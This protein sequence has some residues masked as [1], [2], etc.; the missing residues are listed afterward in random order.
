[1][2][3]TKLTVRF[4]ERLRPAEGKSYAVRDTITRGLMVEVHQ[5]SKVYKVQR[6]VYSSERDTNGRRRKVGTRKVKLGDVQDYD[7]V[8]EARA[9]AREIIRE[10]QRGVDPRQERREALTLRGAWEIYHDYLVA[11]DR[12]PATIDGYR[13]K[14]DLYFPD[15]WDRTM[16]D[17]G[18]DRAAVYER[19]RWLARERGE[20]AANQ[21]MRALRAVYRRARRHHPEL[22]EHPV[23]VVDFRQERRR[24]GAAMS[25]EDLPGWWGEVRALSNPIRRDAQLLGLLSGLRA[26][27]EGHRGGGF[28]LV[29][30][31]WEHVD[32]KARA[33]RLPTT[34]TGRPL[35]IPLS[36]PMVE[37]L[38]RRQAENEALHAGSPWVFPADSKT[39][40][41][42]SLHEQSSGKR[43]VSVTG[44][45]LRH[46]YVTLGQAAGVPREIVSRLVGHSA[47]GNIT[48]SYTHVDAQIEYL[49]SAQETISHY[50]LSNM[51]H[52]AVA[53]GNVVALAV[54]N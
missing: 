14:L 43:K 24:E 53:S 47:G 5:R 28:G 49:R 32:W 48:E 8:D 3:P 12:S 29:S 2:Q 31:R 41:I 23:Q 1:M 50:I 19:H 21:A 17:I 40:H 13:Y 44:H 25:P 45:A 30:L 54:N 51:G 38:E 11:K 18:G 10:L 4:V 20:Y 34:K 37:I 46:S 27:K 26:G 7:T 15:W 42:W 52:P 9:E 36:A 39:G 22:P 33:L 16:A 35:V 6:D